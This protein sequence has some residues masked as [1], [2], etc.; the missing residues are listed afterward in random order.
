MRTHMMVAVLDFD[1]AK[2]KGKKK[3]FSFY[4]FEYGSIGSARASLLVCCLDFLSNSLYF[5][6]LTL[7]EMPCWIKIREKKN[8]LSDSIRFSSC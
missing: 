3:R 4:N 5:S 1:M 2:K 7:N 6:C 8:K